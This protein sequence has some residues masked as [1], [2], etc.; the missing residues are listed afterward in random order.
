MRM[1]GLLKEFGIDLAEEYD[2]LEKE[3]P[4]STSHQRRWRTATKRL[5][6][7]CQ[8]MQLNPQPLPK[9]GDNKRCINCGRCVL[10][11]EQGAKWDSRRF[12]EV[13]VTNG[14][15]LET[16]CRVVRVSI[17]EGRAVG[18][19]A[20]KGLKSKFYPTDLVVVAAGGF[21]TPIILQ[22]SGIECERTLFVDPVL[23]V[24]TEWKGSLQN[25]EISMPFAVQR[26]GYILAPYFD[27]LSYFFRREWNRAPEDTLGIMIK[28]ADSN[29]GS[30]SEKSVDKKLSDQD[31]RRLGDGVKT[32]Y[33]ILGRLGAN[34]TDVFLGTLNAGHPGGMLPLKEN[35]TKSFHSSRLPDNL[36]VADS[37]LL[38][39]S[40]GNPP[41]FTIMAI[42]KRVSKLCAEM[43]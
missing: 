3:V 42:A 41:I 22:N 8:E 12:L 25:K 9:M 13:A 34:T 4:V 7:I 17:K 35:E 32:C 5:F 11:C 33:D 24:A 27:Y 14:A 30:I 38:P 26:D 23:C 39:R 31:M 1:D 15:R 40:L 6:D 43:N 10:G 21:G 37:T 28:L 36:Y 18:V 20:K 29:E 19:I 16:N 2:E